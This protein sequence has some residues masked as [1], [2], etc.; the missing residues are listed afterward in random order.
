MT[1]LDLHHLS[2]GMIEV[3]QMHQL[4]VITEADQVLPKVDTTEQDH[5]D[6]LEVITVQD[7]PLTINTL[8][9]RSMM[10]KKKKLEKRSNSEPMISSQFKAFLR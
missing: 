8:W 7:Q 1:E 5:Q 4:E 6:H 9:Q 2:E 10:K 3:D